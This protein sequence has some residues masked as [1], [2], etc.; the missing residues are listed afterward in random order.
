MNKKIEKI[1]EDTL[2]SDKLTISDVLL[3][4]FSELNLF[5]DLYENIT[6]II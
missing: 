2:V 6:E 3:V 4:S 5:P 1:I